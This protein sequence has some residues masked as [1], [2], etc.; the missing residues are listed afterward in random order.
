MTHNLLISDSFVE[1][2][3]STF[4]NLFD[5]IQGKLSD[6]E[7]DQNLYYQGSSVG[8]RYSVLVFF[9]VLMR[10]VAHGL[11]YFKD[12]VSIRCLNEGKVYAANAS[13]SPLFPFSYPLSMM[14][15]LMRSPS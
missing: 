6:R 13:G 11:V 1:R 2:V 14:K 9:R 10:Q 3:T 5:S 7:S 15:K 8:A 4:S 12:P